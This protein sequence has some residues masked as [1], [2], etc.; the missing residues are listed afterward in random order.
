MGRYLQRME[1]NS[2]YNLR[3]MF[4]IGYLNLSYVK[5]GSFLSEKEREDVLFVM[6]TYARVGGRRCNI[7]T[8][9]MER[10]HMTSQRPYI[11]VAKRRNGGH[12]GV[13]N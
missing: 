3:K 1:S 6:N 8:R 10:F 9:T 13:P 12:I 4:H 2:V 7:H 5:Y 11:A